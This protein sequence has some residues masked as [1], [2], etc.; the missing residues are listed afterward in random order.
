MHRVQDSSGAHAVCAWCLGLLEKMHRVY[1][2]DSCAEWVEADVTCIWERPH[3]R[4]VSCLDPACMDLCRDWMRE[5]G[6]QPGAIGRNI[7][8]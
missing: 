8:P 3:W 1:R 6:N 7:R 2:C 4:C 5:A